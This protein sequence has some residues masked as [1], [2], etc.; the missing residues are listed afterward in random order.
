MGTIDAWASVE[1]IIRQRLE[2]IEHDRR[3]C[4]ICGR[5]GP[6]LS[7]CFGCQMVYYCGEEH[8]AEDWSKEHGNQCVQL[9]WVALGEFIQALPAQPPLPDLGDKWLCS[10]KE[11]HT[12]MH[13]FSIR[14]SIVQLANHTA[15]IFERLA[16]V[17][18]KRQ[19]THQS[20]SKFAS[21]SLEGVNRF[22][23]FV[24]TFI[25]LCQRLTSPIDTYMLRNEQSRDLEWITHQYENLSTPSVYNRTFPLCICFSYFA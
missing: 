1:T 25:W 6:S 19:P 23:V 7:R 15:T 16:H 13:W 17:T 24:D 18:D 4:A 2:S 14:T 11:I 10:L 5:Q 22:D 8:Q 9:E 3:F 12:W 21:L 20:K